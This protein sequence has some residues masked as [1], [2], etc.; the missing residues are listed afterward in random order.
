MIID[1]NKK[2]GEAKVHCCIHSLKSES[3]FSITKEEARFLAV[4]LFENGMDNKPKEIV[5]LYNKIHVFANDCKPRQIANK[6]SKLIRKPLDYGSIGKHSM[7]MEGYNAYYYCQKCSFESG[8]RPMDISFYELIKKDAQK[9]PCKKKAIATRYYPG[10]SV[11]YRRYE[12]ICRDCAIKELEKW[13]DS[14]IRW[15]KNLSFD[16]KPL[17]FS[18]PVDDPHCKGCIHENVEPDIED[19]PPRCQLCSNYNQYDS[20][21]TDRIS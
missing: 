18:G 20:G 10:T 8:P 3:S 13:R 11:T 2:V 1:G 12:P 21:K 15:F 6:N 16:C 5:A 9:C 17:T 7:V 14:H 19:F 4:C